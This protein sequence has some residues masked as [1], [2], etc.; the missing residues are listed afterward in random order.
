MTDKLNELIHQKAR[1]LFSELVAIRRHLHANPELSFEEYKTSEYIQEVLTRH[2]ISFEKNWVRTGIVAVVGKE[3]GF[4]KTIAL[5]GDMDALPIIEANEVEYKSQNEGVMHACGHDVHT[6]CLLGAL[7]ILKESGIDFQNRIIGIF[8]PGEE[9]L[10]GGAQLMIQEGLLSK[11]KPERIIGLHVQPQMEAG[12]VGFCPGKS[13]ASSDEIY[14]TIKGKGGHG[15]LPHLCVDPILIAA[16][17]LSTVQSIASR[18]ANPI[19]PTVLTFGKINSLGGATNVIPDQVMLEGTFRTMDEEWREK[20]HELIIQNIK[21][22]AQ[23]MGGEAD[24]EIRHGYPCLINDD[25]V[26]VDSKQSAI[27]YL[28]HDKVED[29]PPR[30]T[31]EDFAYYSQHVPSCF[32]RLGTGNKEKGIGSSVHTSTFDVDESAIEIGMGLLAFIVAKQMEK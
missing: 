22:T 30:M 23:S 31:S 15:A 28:G 1:E 26:F 25:K 12:S 6:T 9:R 10:P 17:V 3:E 13:M 32:F 2:N 7:I 11:Y 20:A 8:Q 19:I 14:V 27:E 29:F 5:R 21:S 24:I 4:N 16:K 18:N